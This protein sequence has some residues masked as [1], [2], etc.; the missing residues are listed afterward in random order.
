MEIKDRPRI[1]VCGGRNFT[2]RD[3]ID[4][5]LIELC[6]S[7]GW[8]TDSDE[9]G[10]FLP[11][12]TIIHGGARGA[13]LLAGDWAVCNWCPT[14]EYKADWDRLG[15]SA[16]F[17]RNQLM[18]DSKPVLV[19]AFPGGNGTAHTVNRAKVAGIEVLEVHE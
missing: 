17:I 16:G 2:D 11:V 12:V 5:I 3:L 8:V 18:I 9:Y 13:D 19:V 15:K 7:R 10:N 4:S 6:I 14:E 1:L